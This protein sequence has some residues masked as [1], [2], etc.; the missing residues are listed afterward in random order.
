[1]SWNAHECHQSSSIIHL[2]ADAFFASCEQAIHPEYKGRPVI[3]GKERGIVAAASYEAKRMGIDRGVTLIEAKK[4]CP[5]AIIVPSDYETYSLFSKRIFTIMRRFTPSIEEYSIDEAFADISGLRRPLNMSYSQIALRM[6]QEIEKELGITVS[7]GLAPNKVLA[8]IGSKWKKPSGL[9][10]IE[11]QDIPLFLEKTLLNKVWGIGPQ[12]TG[13]L[14][15]Y[16]VRTALDFSKLNENWVL[17]NLTK[18]HREI[19]KELG[20]EKVYP[21]QPQEKNDYASISKFKTFTPPTK[22]KNFIFS[23]LSKNLENAFIKARRHNLAAQKISVVLKTQAFTLTGTEGKLNHATPFPNEA[24]PLVKNMF[25]QTFCS[26]T[27]YRSTGIILSGLKESKDTQLTLFESP[28]KFENNIKLYQSIDELSSR[29]G[30]HSV[31]LGSSFWANS[32]K[33]HLSERGD[34]PATQKLRAGQINERKFLNL[35]TLLYKID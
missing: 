11:A 17:K 3:T 1:M 9:T 30:K 32:Q 4:I 2:D 18:P 22:N 28:L 19:W 10:I 13:H 24:I 26:S 6:K 14:N 25:E 8:K 34:I 15:K 29:F 35:P 16:N 7:V 12:T 23:Q 20:G 27:F 33:S 5:N 21:V 31:F